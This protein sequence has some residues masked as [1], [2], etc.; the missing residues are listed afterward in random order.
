MPTRVG[1][2]GR[3]E[4]LASPR[5]S[6]LSLFTEVP[7]SRILRTSPVSEFSEVCSQK[8]PPGCF[9]IVVQWYRYLKRC[10]SI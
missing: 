7:R 5:P 10:A 8:Q 4:T 9:E 1:R 3:V 2:V 6:Y